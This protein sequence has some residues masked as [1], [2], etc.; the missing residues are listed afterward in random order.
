MTEREQINRLV[1]AAARLEAQRAAIAKG[2]LL[3]AERLRVE[4]LLL[5]VD[6]TPT[7][8][9]RM[10]LDVPQDATGRLRSDERSA[11]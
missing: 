10:A 7:R 1:E 9:E 2:D 6:A 8:Q 3:T 4:A 5:V 11:A